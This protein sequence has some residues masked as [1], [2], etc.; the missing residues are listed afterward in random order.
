MRR[1]L[2]I[3][4]LS[5]FLF[6]CSKKKNHNKNCFSNTNYELVYKYIK[7]EIEIRQ[8]S[9]FEN[10]EYDL[11]LIDKNEIKV[12]KE[13]TLIGNIRNDKG[14]FS[15]AIYKSNNEKLTIEMNNLFCSLISEINSEK[16]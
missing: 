10:N 1:Y 15:I 5:L 4:I 14:I 6:S 7:N 13:K 11:Y 2:V 3:I 16:D 8:Q 12:Y 9:H